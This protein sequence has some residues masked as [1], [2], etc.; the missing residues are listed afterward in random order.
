MTSVSVSTRSQ[1]LP[2]PLEAARDAFSAPGKHHF[3]WRVLA[4]RFGA[5]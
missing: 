2:I 5:A 1:T 3:R 4:E